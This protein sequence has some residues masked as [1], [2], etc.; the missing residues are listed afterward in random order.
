M[1]NE[2][3][4]ISKGRM[5]DVY[6]WESGKILKLNQAVYPAIVAEKEFD[7]AK[8]A[9]AAGLPVPA[10]YEIVERG[11][12][13]GIIFEKVTGG[14]LVDQIKA[15]PLSFAYGARHLADLHARIHECQLP[16]GLESQKGYLQKAIEAAQSITDAE[17]KAVLNYLQQLPEGDRLCHGDFHPDNILLSD[18]GPLIIDWLTGTRGDPA[19]DVCRTLIILET[20]F[21]PPQTPLYF[22]MF[23]A[24]SR[25]WL[26]SIYLNRYLKLNP[27]VVGQ[28]DRWRLPL[29][30]AR[31]REVE[32][33]PHEK[34]IILAKMR[35]LLNSI[36]SN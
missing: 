12:R 7:A 15:K 33:Y 35:K 34:S 17:R 4:F 3:E 18:R 21:L 22:R 10:V 2:L 13:F 24:I 31:I 30:A 14:S 23:H 20:S 8:T 36:P 29:L 25:S 9:Q 27:S 6:A 32:A 11:G 5:A 28:I 16:L 19:A 1:N 26:N